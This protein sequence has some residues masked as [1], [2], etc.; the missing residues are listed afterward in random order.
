MAKN[1][2][3][4]PDIE[5]FEL[6]TKLMGLV[7]LIEIKGDKMPYTSMNGNMFSFLKEGSVALRLSEVDRCEFIKKFK[8]QLFET[9]G[10]VMKEYVTISPTQ[11]KKSKDLKPFV[12][13]SFDYAKTL[14][15]KPTKKK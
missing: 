3:K 6:Y 7:P 14:K 4:K 13:K 12:K 11:L 1:K 15:A 2:S 9:Y 8:S 10:T 5:N